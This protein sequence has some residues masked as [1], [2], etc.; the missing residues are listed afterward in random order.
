MGSAQVSGGIFERSGIG[1]KQTWQA[2]MEAT[3]HV[4]ILAAKNDGNPEAKV[5]G[6]ADMVQDVPNLGGVSWGGPAGVRGGVLLW[7]SA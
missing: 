1:F 2:D 6:I 7:L 3:M 5:G 4:L